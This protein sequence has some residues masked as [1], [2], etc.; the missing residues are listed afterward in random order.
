M[1]F[2]F[3]HCTCAQELNYIRYNTNNS[4]L[5]HDVTYKLRQDNQG[6]IWVCTDDGLIRFNGTEMVSFD[7]GFVSKY[8]ISTDEEHGRVWASTWKG[9]IQYIRNDSAVL[10]KT[11]PMATGVVYNTNNVIAFNDLVIAYC[12]KMYAVFKFDSINNR[13]LPYALDE[14]PGAYYRSQPGSKNYY[15]FFKSA[16]HHLYAYNGY[17]FYEVINNRLKKKFLPLQP[18]DVWQSPSGILYM[19]AGAGI[20]T[21]SPGFSTVSLVYTIPA[22]AVDIANVIK[23][24]VLP[25]GNICLMAETNAVR[26]AWI[27]CF[28]INT[29]NGSVIDVSKAVGNNVCPADMLIDKEGGMWLS[30]D[31]GGLYHI[32][33]Q[34]FRQIGSDGFFY[35]THITS[36]MPFTGDSIVIATRKGL[37]L[38]YKRTISPVKQPGHILNSAVRRLFTTPAGHIGFLNSS[39]SHCGQAGNAIIN[40]TIRP[41]AY[42]EIFVMK[43]YVFTLYPSGKIILASRQG[44]QDYSD[45]MNGM[46][47]MIYAVAEDDKGGLW[48]STD[49]AFHYFH[50]GTGLQQYKRRELDNVRINSLKYVA[51]RGLYL[52][53]SNGLFLL[54]G[55]GVMGHWGIKDGLLNLNVR[56]LLSENAGSLWLGTQN[57]LFNFKNDRFSIYKQRDGLIA[58]D[59][60]CIAWADKGEIAV[61]GSQGLTMFC[62]KDA[63]KPPGAELVIEKLLVNDVRHNWQ[64]PISVPYKSNIFLKYG[65]VTFIYPEL[66]EYQYRLNKDEKWITTQNSSLVFTGLKPGSYAFELKAKRYDSGYSAPLLINFKIL[67]PWWRSAYFYSA[68]FAV[69]L[70]LVLALFRLRL[71]RQ[72]EKAFARY[73]LAELKMKALQ[74]QLNPHF[75]S[76]ALNAIQH[77]ILTRDEIAANDYLGRFADLTRLFL[78]MSR[79]GLVSISTELELLNNYLSLEKLRFENKFDFSIAVDPSVDI[80]RDHIPGLLVQPFVE[81]SIN[82]GIVYLPKHIKGAVSICIKKEGDFISIVINDNGIGRKKATEIKHRLLRAHRSHSGKIVEEM[83]QAYNLLPGCEIMIETGNQYDATHPTPG[84]SVYIKVKISDTLIRNQPF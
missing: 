7:K 1:F 54:T 73:E 41:L 81:N 83:A 20:Y 58:D 42:S 67:P 52:G 56:S 30:T 68:V 21:V 23:F 49:V 50:P 59:V 10:L 12:F 47:S 16:A 80:V 40:G 70:I 71:K 11:L 6:F 17:G 69:F 4:K 28:F 18:D 3:Y 60:N 64:T 34:K 32:F 26:N 37:Y 13:L 9:G 35:N 55:N 45:K 66:V 24:R 76:N 44:A 77:F 82:H 43:N 22:G 19:R 39:L 33:D 48:I 63:A 14:G 57:G 38:Y 36:L 31:G 15:R 74:A 62:I 51:G 65:V 27:S 61:G 2:L 5:P 75:I 78:E 8:I 29:H 84:T 46:S 53:T 79:E 72:K 25:S